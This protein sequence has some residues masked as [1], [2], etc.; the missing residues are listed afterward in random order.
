M[1]MNQN[2]NSKFRAQGTY[3]GCHHQIHCRHHQGIPGRGHHR[4]HQRPATSD[5]PKY[6]ATAVLASKGHRH[7][8]HHRIHPLVRVWERNPIAPSPAG[9]TQAPSLG[10]HQRMTRRRRAHPGWASLADER[11]HE[12]TIATPVG[13]RQPC[14]SF[15]SYLTRRVKEKCGLGLRGGQALVPFCLS[16][17]CAR[18]SR[19]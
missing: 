12:D 3:H 9:T 6:A 4:N 14:H 5:P 7:T 8:S 18:P 10:R 1:E 13:H 15:L 16:E 2:P 11:T 19:N 17:G